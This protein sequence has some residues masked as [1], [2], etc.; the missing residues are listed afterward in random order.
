MGEEKTDNQLMRE[1]KGGSDAAYE[2]IV[3]RYKDRL[4]NYVL[5]AFRLSR[6]EGED[7]VQKTM[8]RVNE[9]RFRYAARHE[10]STWV[11]TIARNF[12][13]NELQR[14][15]INSLDRMP[16]LHEPDSPDDNPLDV[17]DKKMRRERLWSIVKGM[18]ADCREVLWLLYHD[19][20]KYKEVSGITQ[21]KVNTLKS[22]AR[23][24]LD[25]LRV[26][27]RVKDLV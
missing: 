22:V 13:L 6:D 11:Y 23:R 16:E 8:I 12:A 5:R 2:Q 18:K 17:V 15:P 27:E 3:Q 7:V 24:C 21:K 10:F 25:R 9:Y 14:R 20:L 4:F 26:D 19:E 1:F